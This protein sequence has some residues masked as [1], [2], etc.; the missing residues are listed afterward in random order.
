[1]NYDSSRA[2][3]DSAAYQTKATSGITSAVAILREKYPGQFDA[4]KDA[5]SRASSRKF[6]VVTSAIAAIVLLVWLR[7]QQLDFIV[8]Y[9]VIYDTGLV[10]GV[11]MLLALTYSLRKRMRLLKNAGKLETWYVLHLTAGI[12]GPLLIVFHS[13]FAIKSINSLI[14]ILAM[15]LIVGSGALGR[16]LFTRLS[17]IMHSKLARIDRE[18]QQLFDALVKYDSDIIR[19][20]L[21]RLTNTCLVQ[22]KTV[23][24]IPY[25]Y[26][27]VRAQAANCYVVAGGQITRV[28]LEV[29]RHANWD[30]QTLEA[31]VW[32]EKHYLKQYINTLMDVSLV[33]SCEQLLSKWRWFHVP[34]MYLLVLCTLAHVL[35]VHAY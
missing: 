2:G 6:F 35:V 16:F 17:F 34:V 4:S 33:R 3:S 20:Q 31:T 19:K 18:E 27:L 22:P 23:F 15:V 25:A 21:S 7:W 5:A 11:L 30:Q 24:H 8:D 1:M 32:Q 13:T 26:L 12:S 29:A 9:D 14:A 10:G 28:L